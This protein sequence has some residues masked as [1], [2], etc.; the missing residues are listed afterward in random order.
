MAK[1]FGRERELAQINGRNAVSQQ[2]VTLSLFREPIRKK[3]LVALG[4]GHE[5]RHD[6]GISGI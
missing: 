6:N 4:V 2:L 3:H 5:R 1:M